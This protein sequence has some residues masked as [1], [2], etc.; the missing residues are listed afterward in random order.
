MSPVLQIVFVLTSEVPSAVVETCYTS[1]PDIDFLYVH[2]SRN[3]FLKHSKTVCN[4]T[5]KLLSKVNI[6]NFVSGHN[7]TLFTMT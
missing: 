5:S 1:I 4:V 6:E 3:E 7:I 2:E